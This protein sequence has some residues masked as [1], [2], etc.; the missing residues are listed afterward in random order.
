MVRSWRKKGRV[1]AHRLAPAPTTE[2]EEDNDV[3]I[4]SSSV[5][6]DGSARSGPNH[7]NGAVYGHALRN[8]RRLPEPETVANVWQAGDDDQR[9]RSSTWVSTSVSTGRLTILTHH[10]QLIGQR[11]HGFASYC[12]RWSAMRSG[13][14]RIANRGLTGLGPMTYA[15]AGRIRQPKILEDR[16]NSNSLSRTLESMGALFLALGSAIRAAR[17][18]RAKRS[19][20]PGGLAR[21]GIQRDASSTVRWF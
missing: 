18:V 12:L 2:P 5:R 10:G 7:I 17:A 21:L 8:I 19:P 13:H 4:A 3:P 6:M 1:V 15:E 9:G 14:G 16:M 11:S 20:A